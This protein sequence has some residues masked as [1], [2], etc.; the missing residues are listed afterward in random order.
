MTATSKNVKLPTELIDLVK[1]RGSTKPPGEALLDITK[2]YVQLEMLAKALNKNG[3]ST[4]TT[5]FDAVDAHIKEGDQ[6]LAE[7]EKSISD[8]KTMLTG[9]QMVFSKVGKYE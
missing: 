7:L 9:L 1:S 4:L 8:L 2:D 6:K 3:S 5:V